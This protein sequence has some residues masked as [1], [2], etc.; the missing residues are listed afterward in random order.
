MFHFY[1]LEE[2]RSVS[3]Y[4]LSVFVYLEGTSL[5]EKDITSKEE[6]RM[7]AFKVLS[8]GGGGRQ[9]WLQNNVV[10]KCVV[11]PRLRHWRGTLV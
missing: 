4:I 11:M 7:R 5:K 6:E 8:F 2:D 1:Q 10:Y 9:D 3:K